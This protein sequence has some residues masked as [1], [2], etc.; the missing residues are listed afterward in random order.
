MNLC[1]PLERWTLR[2]WE[3]LGG[4]RDAQGQDVGAGRA[5][6]TP[7]VQAPR[8]EAGQH[9]AC[10]AED[11]HGGDD[12]RVDERAHG[13][14]DEQGPGCGEDAP[15]AAPAVAGCLPRPSHGVFSSWY[16]AAAWRPC[17]IR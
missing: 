10:E 15:E 8:D 16:L 6:V 4:P 1:G 11:D 2:L 14:H 9:R 17:R 3:G 7:L 13:G 5:W 12:E